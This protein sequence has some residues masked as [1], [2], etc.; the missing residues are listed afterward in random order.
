MNQAL[1]SMAALLIVASGFSI[2]LGGRRLGGWLLAAAIAVLLLGPFLAAAPALVWILLLIGLSIAALRAL[3]TFSIGRHGASE[4]LG[5]LAAELIRF[6]VLAPFRF[7]AF[8]F[9][10]PR[11]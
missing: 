9:G 11:P 7:I 4:A 8:L 6:V 3:L 2:M 5:I 1:P 10:R